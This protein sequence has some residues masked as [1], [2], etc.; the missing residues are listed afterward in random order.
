MA[1]PSANTPLVYAL[2][3][4]SNNAAADRALVDA[5]PDLSADLQDV[6]L[7]TLIQRNRPA[8]LA[9]VVTA[10]PAWGSSL[11]ERV[12]ARAE[13]L[14]AGLRVAVDSD[15]TETRLAAV[16]IIR[17]G[18][19]V[20]CAY[21]LANAL[22]R[23]CPRTRRAAG[24]AIEQLVADFVDQS[25]RAQAAAATDAEPAS[26][27]RALVDAVGEA[28][29]CWSAHRRAEV[30]RAAM[31]L[32]EDLEEV[33]LTRVAQPRLKL[34]RVFEESLR[35]RLDPRMAA[36]AV[37][38]LR[39]PALRGPAATWIG[40]CT[41]PRTMLALLDQLWLTGDVEVYRS[42]SSIRRL[43]WLEGG[44]APVMELQSGRAEA[45]AVLIASSGL[46]NE[47]KVNL[48]ASIACCGPAA[49]ARAAVW[50][51]VGNRTR[52]GSAALRQVCR[53][54]GADV[55]RLAARELERRER[56]GL[57]SSGFSRQAESGST[58][59]G[60]NTFETYWCAFD[61]LDVARQVEFGA[62]LREQLSDFD[63]PLRHRLAANDPADRTRAV[64]MV[65]RLELHEAFA[66]SLYELAHDADAVVRSVVTRALGRL[67]NPTSRR[68]LS[69]ALH[70]P[71]A[72]VQ[73]NAIEA[74]DTLEASQ[75]QSAVRDKLASPNGRVRAN[76]VKMLLKLEL[77]EAVDAL[78]NM[79]YGA[80]RSDRLSALWVIECLRLQ[81]LTDRLV[82]L[83]SNDP[84][85]QVRH[86][87]VQVARS[88]GVTLPPL[89]IPAAQE[90]VP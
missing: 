44:I 90:T 84:D 10:C 28:M 46:P 49:P 41:D 75:Y 33:I 22:T 27:R 42:L 62:R 87:A 78:L 16:E 48:L 72:R 64:R 3:A 65:Q 2:L 43:A 70:D 20:R 73:A 69:A 35:G 68:I 45:A 85:P 56:G 61:R 88:V 36:Y 32:A 52:E 79:L 8:G 23:S 18:N 12:T 89:A 67:D 63:R 26:P 38:A 59:A 17:R 9:L 54:A 82:D 30:V 81:S 25:W 55:S 66:E 53:H 14:A 31:W 51:L 86:R 39:A 60:L 19:G 5:L 24:Q 13:A 83:A 76:A 6:A 58:P 74:L 4:E 37:R 15:S 50:Q 29:N 47:T 77:R 1:H 71:D 34:A 57:L 11:R 7:D 21:L 80:A 40:N